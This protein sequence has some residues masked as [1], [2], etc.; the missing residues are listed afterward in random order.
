MRKIT[1]KTGKPQQGLKPQV[2]RL[3]VQFANHYINAKHLNNL[4][5]QIR[6]CFC[7]NNLPATFK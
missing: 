6:L 5:I 3:P 7:K 4:C 2:S 1:Q